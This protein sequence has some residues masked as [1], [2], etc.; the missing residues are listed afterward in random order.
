MNQPI[1]EKLEARGWQVGSATDF[2]GLTPEDLL[3]I[4]I[5]L[6]LSRRLEERQQQ[7]MSEEAR[8][9]QS[10]QTQQTKSPT[11]IDQLIRDMVATG[12]SPQ[13]IGQLI[14]NTD[15]AVA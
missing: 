6:A 14:A 10:N 7:A 15:M 11:S 12:S 2:L 13:E 1:K 5:K 9:N 3:I 4:E 8:L